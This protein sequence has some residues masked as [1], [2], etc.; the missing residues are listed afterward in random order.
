METAKPGNRYKFR[1][2]FSWKGKQTSDMARAGKKLTA[3]KIILRIFCVLLVT[4][5]LLCAFLYGVI[6]LLCRGPSETARNLFVRSVRETSAIGFLANLCLSDAEIEAIEASQLEAVPETDVS[7]IEMASLENR[8][9]DENGADAWGYVD[10]DGDGVIVVPVSGGTY[11]GY[12]L[13]VLDPMQVKL[14][15]LLRMSE[16]AGSRSSAAEMMSTT[17]ETSI[18]MPARSR[19]S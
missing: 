1:I 17:S 6:F 16:S 2:T 10:D 13:I 15:F 8:S 18:S 3:G 12:M 4:L 14:G 9:T 19:A 7:M 5:L 11:S